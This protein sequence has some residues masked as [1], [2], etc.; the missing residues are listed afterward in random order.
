[1]TFRKRHYENKNILYFL[2][3][4]K[5]CPTVQDPVTCQSNS[6]EDILPL[7]FLQCSC[8]QWRTITM[9]LKNGSD[10][11]FRGLGC[12]IPSESVQYG[13]DI[14]RIHM[15]RTSINHAV[16]MVLLGGTGV[17]WVPCCIGC[18]RW[19]GDANKQLFPFLVLPK[20][21]SFPAWIII[22]L[23]SF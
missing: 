3:C 21:R 22:Y 10:L 5:N 23:H 1:M 15:E 17:I 8:M 12:F 18:R 4:I 19:I 16:V 2:Y 7:F 20:R 14:L 9:E 11:K 6:Q 13:F